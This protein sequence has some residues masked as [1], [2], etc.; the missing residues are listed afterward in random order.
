MGI[1]RRVLL[2]ALV[3]QVIRRDASAQARVHAKPQPL[4]KDAVTHDWTSFLGP[5]HNS[6]S[7]ETRLSRTLPPPL[8]W[9]F[10]K[11]TSYTSPAIIGDRLLFVHRV[12]DEEVVECLHA[13]TGARHW[14]FRYATDFE[15]RYGYN[16]GPRS[17][18][19]LMAT[20]SMTFGAQGKLHCL[21][22]RTGKLVWQRNIAA[23]YKVPQDFFGTASTPLVEDK[24]LIST[25]ARRAVRAWRTRQIDRPRSVARGQRVGAELCIARSRSRAR[26]APRL[27]VRRRRIHTTAGGLLSIDPSN[28]RVDFSFPWRS[29]HTSQ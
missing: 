7:T 28:G 17:S 20:A 13:E 26:Q 27:C 29:R 11:G 12:G 4:A 15:D 21:D 1:S 2:Q 14:S 18:P 22:L 10:A 6:V 9:E 24:L 8:V 3:A 16:N 19:V 25:W 23:E 5:S